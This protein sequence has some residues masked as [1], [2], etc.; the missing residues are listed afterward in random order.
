[1][2]YRD[3]AKVGAVTENCNLTKICKF[4][5]KAETLFVSREKCIWRI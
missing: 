5:E 4:R 3:I 1:M 2:I